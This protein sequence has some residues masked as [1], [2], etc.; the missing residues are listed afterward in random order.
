M[1]QAVNQPSLEQL[2]ALSND[3]LSKID[4]VVMNLVVAKG[5]P[6]LANLDIDQYVLLADRWADDLRRRMPLMEAE[7]QKTPQHWDNDLLL[8][9]LG[10]VC[11]YVDIVLGVKYREDHANLKEVLYTDPADLFINGVMDTRRGTC[12]NLAVLH[13]VLARRVG[14]PMSLACAGAHYLCRYDDGN[15]TRN[16]EATQAGFGGFSSK[17]D[18]YVLAKHGL[19]PLAQECGSDLRAV[20]PREMLGLFVGARARHL[21]NSGHREQSEPDYLLARY[22]FPQN[23]R[24]YMAQTQI[25]VELS[26]KRFEANE[27][28]HPAG[29]AKWVQFIANGGWHVESR[30]HLQQKENTNG[31]YSN[32]LG[33]VI[34]VG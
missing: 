18:D 6:S 16:I 20:T 25:S 34:V 8:F 7:F 9:R 14:F 17:P 27:K 32:P 23:R 24:L 30:D 4:P 33:S 29:L 31:S 3:E 1:S 2:L 26:Q 12:G 21:D 19:P 11:W 5:I 22:L 15:V 13:V 10:L 28:G